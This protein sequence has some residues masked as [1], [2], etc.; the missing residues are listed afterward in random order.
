MRSV[1]HFIKDES[2]VALMTVIGVIGVMTVLSLSAFAFAQST[3]HTSVRVSNDTQA[4]QAANS[5]VDVAL[6]RIQQNGYGV[7]DYPVTGTG[8]SGATYVATVTPENNSEYLCASTGTYKGRTET[9]RIKF[10]YL[11]IWNMN[12][13]AGADNALG[14]G[15]VKGTTSVYGPFYV[16]GGV[17]LGSNSRIENGPLFINSGDLT[18]TGSGSIGEAGDIDVY[19]TGA[20][21]A[22]GSKGMHARNISSSVPEISLPQVDAAYLSEKYML[23]KTESVDNVVGYSDSGDVGYEATLL[24]PATYMTLDPPS[25]GVTNWY[26]TTTVK[27]RQRATG[28]SAYYKAIGSDSG[29]GSVGAGTYPFTIGGASFGSWS[30]DGKY[31]GTKHDD[32]AY[33]DATNTLY[34]EGTVF[35]DGPLT[36]AEDVQYVGNGSLIANGNI[37]LNGDFVAKTANLE[38]DATHCVGLVTPGNIICDT[39]DSNNKSPNDPPNVA[40]AFFASKDWSMTRN[41]VVKGSVLA[42]SISFEHANQHLVTDPD[43]PS[44]LPRSMPGSGQSVLTKGAWVR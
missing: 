37:T 41:V 16:R 5:G 22:N 36:I 30:G 38:A 10:F 31:P 20:H 24:N 39:G 42:G 4:F 13:A 12:M 14:G 43:L 9:I 19:V 44:Y 40:G 27:Y 8:G 25:D 15:S 7:A 1:R 17:V 6:A 34:V 35:I 11:N 21:P 32:F 28:A 26:G 2:G 23:A 33:D 29:I 3:L 18:I